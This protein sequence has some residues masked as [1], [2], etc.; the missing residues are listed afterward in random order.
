MATGRDVMALDLAVI[1]WCGGIIDAIGM[2][3]VRTTPGGTELAYVAVSTPQLAIARRLAELTGATVTTVRRD[4]T[5][6]GCTEHCE[7][8]HLH[9][10]STTGR[11]SLTGAKAVVFLAAVQPYIVTRA[12]DVAEVLAATGDA[13]NKPATARKMHALGWP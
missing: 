13:P 7:A 10:N 4:Y 5:R 9:V 6:V 8:A 1:A 2:V 11:W 12:D 3:R